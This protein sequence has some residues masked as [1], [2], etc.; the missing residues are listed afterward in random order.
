[1]VEAAAPKTDA[2]LVGSGDDG[3]DMAAGFTEVSSGILAF[4]SPARVPKGDVVD[5]E[6]SRAVPSTEVLVEV[7]VAGLGASAAD[8]KVVGVEDPNEANPVPGDGL[9]DVSV[10]GLDVDPNAKAVPDV[11]AANPADAGLVSEEDVVEPKGVGAAEAKA[12]KPP[13]AA[14]FESVELK[15]E[16]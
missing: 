15:A 11:K 9:E 5:D 3:G 12:E 2:A 14:G 6:V 8:A 16:G 13:D 7:L 4:A 10:A 1:M